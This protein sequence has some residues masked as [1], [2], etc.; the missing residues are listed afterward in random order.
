M[1]WFRISPMMELCE[2]SK[3]KLKMEN[4]MTSCVANNVSRQHIMH[5]TNF[6]IKFIRK[7]IINI[8]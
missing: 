1:N 3:I 2:S 7:V 5:F 6:E 4:F 8:I